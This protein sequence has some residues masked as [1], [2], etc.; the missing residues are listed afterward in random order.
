M[1]VARD[2][3]ALLDYLNRQFANVPRVV[4]LMDRRDD[5][6]LSSTQLEPERRQRSGYDHDVRLHWVVV[7]DERSDPRAA[8]SPSPAPRE[9]GAGSIEQLH[10]EVAATEDEMARL[11]D[12]LE[13]LRRELA[14]REG[15]GERPRKPRR[16]PSA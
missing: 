11:R 8:P 10:A 9:P 15:R 12:R 3:P 7:I 4:V 13:A 1:I 6:G 2:Q 14:A 5:V 16:D